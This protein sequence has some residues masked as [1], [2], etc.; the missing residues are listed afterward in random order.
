MLKI[1]SQE[2]TTKELKN[3]IDAEHKRMLERWHENKKIRTMARTIKL[4]E[5]LGELCN[6]I[7]AYNTEQR[8]EKMHPKNSKNLANEFAD[9]IIVTLLLA[10]NVNIDVYRA[11]K[12][13]IKK[14]EKRWKDSE[15]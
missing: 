6:E 15:Y 1:K 8:K 3:F 13:K 10:E 9:V 2:L 5:E 12:N 7:M 11:L 14:I 4:M